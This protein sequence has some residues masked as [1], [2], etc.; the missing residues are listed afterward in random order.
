MRKSDLLA[1][2]VIAVTLVYYLFHFDF[3]EVPS[4]DYIGNFRA[5]VVAFLDGGFKA[6]SNKVLPL[7]PLVLAVFSS[8]TGPYGNDAIYTNALLLNYLFFAVYIYAVYIVYV[9][10]LGK[11]F[12]IL[13]II[14]LLINS[15][16]L[17]MLI[18][19]E[20]E[21]FLAAIS[22]LSF[23][24]ML[25]SGTWAA[26]P[27]ALTSLVKWDAVFILPSYAWRQFRKA[28]SIF[29]FILLSALASIP[30]GLWMLLIILGSSGTNAYVEEIASRGPNIY[31]FLIDAFLV[32][33]GFIQWAAV[34]LYYEG[35]SLR[36]V[37]SAPFILFGSFAVLYLLFKGLTNLLKRRDSFTDSL[38]IY[39]GGYFLV[40]L[41]YQNSKSRYV[42]PVLWIL[43]L[44]LCAGIKEI[45]ES[46]EDKRIAR[47]L[48]HR[49]SISVLFVAAGLLLHIVFSTADLLVIM[50]T[51][52]AFILLFR[53]F[54]SQA[55]HTAYFLLLV[56]FL[57]LNIYFGR[58][59][60][61]HYSLRRVEFKRL[62]L[63]LNDQ[64]PVDGNILISERNVVNYYST[65]D[66]NRFVM[67]MSISASNLSELYDE[68]I[69]KNINLVYVDDFY[70]RRLDRN[71]KNAIDRKASLLK[72]V[73][74]DESGKFSLVRSFEISDDIRGYLYE[75]IPGKN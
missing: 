60:L 19:A 66:P 49:A 32:V 4:A 57:L 22:A 62:S 26:L 8:L 63:Y 43:N 37:F 2:S 68:L 46:G 58:T 25:R 17:Y 51:V 27:V 40:H 14:I 36:A 24:L 38:F 65:L 11:E 34:D 64:A 56:C 50:Y 1:V 74:D 45:A 47:V 13:S 35:F 28:P 20:L 70:V 53:M 7:Y 15:F 42:L 54:R 30:F 67:S 6:V 61:D 18:N 75:V 33:S 52:A 59:M 16:S 31:R 39:T 48:K 5:F 10:I 9:E 21:M 73:R 3:L 69:E 44:V 29:R 55:K 12:G 41:V 23:A 72:S 71:D